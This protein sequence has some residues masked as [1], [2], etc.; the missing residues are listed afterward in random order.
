MKTGPIVIEYEKAGKVSKKKA[1]TQTEKAKQANKF[2]KSLRNQI[3]RSMAK[4]PGVNSFRNPKTYLKQTGDMSQNF[5]IRKAPDL[6]EM[7]RYPGSDFYCNVYSQAEHEQITL[8]NHPELLNSF[9]KKEKNLN[10]NGQK[11]K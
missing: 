4:T 3:D 1:V 9:K 11:I 6:V 2:S 10:K 7:D 5:E 8:K